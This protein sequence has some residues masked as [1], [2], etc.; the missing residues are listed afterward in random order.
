MKNKYWWQESGDELAKQI[1]SYVSELDNDQYQIH[2]DNLK[3]LRLYGNYEIM[4]A[5]SFTD[6]NSFNTFSTQNRV[7]LNIVQSM[8][9]TVVSKITKNKPKPSFLT[10]GGDWS[11]QQKAK[12]LTKF[13]E[14][15]F[16]STEFYEKAAKAFQDACI[17]G[18]GAVKI[19]ID[20]DMEIKAE[21]VF[22]DEIKVN[23]AESLFEKPTQLHQVKM[24]H[25]E[26]L[27]AMYPD[28][29]ADIEAIGK[30]EYFNYVGDADSED[31]VKVTES[32]HLPSTEESTDGKHVIS[33]QNIVLLEEEY[34][35]N[36]F[37]FVFFRWN[38]RPVGFFGQGIPEQLTGLQLEINKLLRTI[39]VSM[40][41]VSVP[42]IFI[43]SASKI[44][45]AHINNK[46]GGVIRFQGNPPRS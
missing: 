27:K 17:F 15:Q 2:Q 19:Y 10:S 37:P 31:M 24:M 26:T 14:G 16:Y 43:D 36:Y 42:K 6:F 28:K 22:I 12:K 25:K 46:I 44:V 9:D 20:S 5:Q 13:C 41:L 21:R 34:T 3:N 38:D 18:T 7:T 8:V 4:G 33:C 29:E 11:L 23:M 39:Q 30:P 35:K 40:H 1:H 45:D 32:W